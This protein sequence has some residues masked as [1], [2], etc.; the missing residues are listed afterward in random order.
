MDE[1]KIINSQFKVLQQI[2]AGSFGVVFKGKDQKNNQLVAI[3][4]EKEVS[5]ETIGKWNRKNFIRQGGFHLR[6]VAKHSWSP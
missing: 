6:Q 3:K 5:I 2:N 4:I 1:I